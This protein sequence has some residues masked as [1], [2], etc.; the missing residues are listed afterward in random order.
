MQNFD[1]KAISG[2]VASVVALAASL[3]SKFGHSLTATGTDG[4]SVAVGGVEALAQ[5]IES[6]D[7]QKLMARIATL[8]SQVN[9][10]FATIAELQRVVAPLATQLAG[11]V[12]GTGAATGPDAPQP[13]ATGAV[14]PVAVHKIEGSYSGEPGQGA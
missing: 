14:A 5:V 11:I 12:A 9:S 13:A 6:F 4:K 2:H 3:A 10:A 7:P 1:P 8:E